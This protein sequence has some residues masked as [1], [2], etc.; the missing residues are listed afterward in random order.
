MSNGTII[1]Q[2]SFTSAGTNVTLNIPSGTD[3]IELVNYTKIVA[4]AASTGYQ[5]YWQL[6]MPNGVGIET[7]SN[8]GANAVDMIPTAANAF[9]LV[10]TSA[11]PNGA[12]LAITAGTNATRPVYTATITGLSDGDV[13]RLINVAGN[14]N[15][16]GMD[17]T[18][19]AVGGGTFRIANTLANAPGAV[20]GAGLYR[21]IKYDPIFYP[22][23]RFIANITAAAQAVVTTTVN[24][25]YT[26]GQ[27]IRFNVSAPYGMT[28]INGL[29]GNIV[30]I[31]ASTFTVDI[32]SSAFTAFTFPLA[33]S[34]PF[35]QAT[36]NP[37]GETANANISNPNLL[38][39]ATV[40][41]AI[42]G[43]Q[44]VGGTADSPAGQAADV[45]YWKVGK[46]FNT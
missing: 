46:S 40:N 18:V 36:V 10:D 38:D 41:N 30:A 17:F 19:D 20:G 37:V 5:F 7:Q 2:G 42:I 1:Q 12:A 3:W 16:S 22:T 28:Q 34:I 43:I 8:A 25:A 39:D 31:T 35:S 23:R 26:V 6:G 13:V 44:L 15:L 11:N 14:L 32:D 21:R 4:N 45:I 33:A 29:T 27:Q 9:T 24:H